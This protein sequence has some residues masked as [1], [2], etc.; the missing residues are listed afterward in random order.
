MAIKTFYDRARR[1]IVEIVEGGKSWL[2]YRGNDKL[3]H[4]IKTYDSPDGGGG[5]DIQLKTINGESLKGTGNITITT[6]VPVVGVSGTTPTQELAPN[7]FYKFGTVTSL[8]LTLHLPVDG[9]VNIYAYSFTAGEN[10]DATTAIPTGV[11]LDRELEIEE[12]QFCEVSIQDGHATYMVWPA[13]EA[14]GE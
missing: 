4:Y 8:T 11:T 3:F 1:T 2:R 14:E 9:I 7:T 6:D 5:D 13:P 12:G 10:F